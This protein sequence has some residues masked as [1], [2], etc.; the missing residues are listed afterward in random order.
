[1]K[2]TKVTSQQSTYVAKVASGLTAED[3]AKQDHVSV[4][5]VRYHLQGLKASMDA[6]SLPQAVAKAIEQ[7]LI[8]PDG[9]GGYE[10]VTRN[11]PRRGHLK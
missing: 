2:I 7:N 10:P 4:P 3:I 9:Q 6:D 5:T 8:K 1:M 11:D